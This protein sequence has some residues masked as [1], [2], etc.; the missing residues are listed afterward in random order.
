MVSLKEKSNGQ[1]ESKEENRE[2]ENHKEESQE[3]S[4]E[5]ESQEESQ[6]EK[7]VERCNPKL[8]P[9]QWRTASLTVTRQMEDSLVQRENLPFF[10]IHPQQN[11]LQI[12]DTDCFLATGTRRAYT[13]H[14]YVYR[15]GDLSGEVVKKVI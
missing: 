4:D 9:P 1:E 11:G 10:Y 3:E 2:E 5:E 14:E 15:D 12:P 6:E 7:I 13:I 8:A